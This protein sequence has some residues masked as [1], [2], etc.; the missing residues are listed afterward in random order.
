[1]ENWIRLGPIYF[2]LPNFETLPPL[3]VVSLGSLVHQTTRTPGQLNVT[4]SSAFV[5]SLPSNHIFHNLHLC[6]WLWLTMNSFCVKVD[7]AK[8]VDSVDSVRSCCSER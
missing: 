7:R 2:P 6:F 8:H 1:M 5:P 3:T 4:C